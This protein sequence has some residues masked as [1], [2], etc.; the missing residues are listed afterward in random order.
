MTEVKGSKKQEAPERVHP[1]APKG[2][3]TDAEVEALK[4]KHGEVFELI[5]ENSAGYLRRPN[6]KELSAATSLGGIDIMAFNESLLA[7]CWLAGDE[8]IKTNDWLFLAACRELPA[9]IEMKVSTLKKR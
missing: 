8:D 9:L 2:K 4:A 3:L 5:I 6:R 7:D 1:S